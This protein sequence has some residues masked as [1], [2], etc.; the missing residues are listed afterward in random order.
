MA[1]TV[2]GCSVDA[3]PCPPDAQTALTV[4]EFIVGPNAGAIFN[5]VFFQTFYLACFA[6]CCGMFVRMILDEGARR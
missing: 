4:G 6:W 2:I 1:L 3:I 5:Y